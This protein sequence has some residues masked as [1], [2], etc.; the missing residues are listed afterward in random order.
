MHFS[1]SSAVTG[2]LC[3]VLADRE[4]TGW[5]ENSQPDPSSS[6]DGEEEEPQGG[7]TAPGYCL[8]FLAQGEN[9]NSKRMR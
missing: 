7:G 6:R 2:D 4:E 9:I 1:F 8:F 5:G 3:E